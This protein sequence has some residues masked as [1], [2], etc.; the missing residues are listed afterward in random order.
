LK[1]VNFPNPL[2]HTYWWAELLVALYCNPDFQQVLVNLVNLLKK[3]WLLQVFQDVHVVTG[4]V[5]LS[6]KISFL[7]LAKR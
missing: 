6:L 4:I 5:S 2:T 7:E 3:A 1:K